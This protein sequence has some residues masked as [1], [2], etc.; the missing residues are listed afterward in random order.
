MTQLKDLFQEEDKSLQHFKDKVDTNSLPRK[1]LTQFVESHTDL[2][3]QSKVITRVSDRLQSKLNN[4]NEK[5]TVQHKTIAEK[6]NLLQH[7][8][9]Q[10]I[11]AKVSKKA[12][13]VLLTAAILLFLAEEVLLEGVIS[14]FI[15]VPYIGLA[16]KLMM[17]FILKGFESTLETYFMRKEQEKILHENHLEEANAASPNVP[18]LKLERSVAPQAR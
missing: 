5:I 4:A 8:V 10:L 18:A 7:T 9:D 14:T 16:V 17:A 15:N 2:L 12:S 11:R 1:D 13:R 3:T 6:N